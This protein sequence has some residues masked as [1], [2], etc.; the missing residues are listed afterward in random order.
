MQETKLGVLA[1]GKGTGLQAILDHIRLGVLVNVRT[2]C[3]VSNNNDAEVMRR[4]S[5]ANIATIFVEG[6]AGKKFASTDEKERRRREFDNIASKTFS[7]HGVDLIVC[8]GFN[9]VLSEVLVG[10]YPNKIMNI[11]PAYD[12]ARFGGIGMVGLKVHQAV[13]KAG[14]KVSGCTV[15]FIDSTVDRGPIILR[16]SVPVFEGDTPERLADRVSVI[17]HR[18]Y[19]KA[20]QLHVDRRIIVKN[21]NVVL[22]LSGDW[23]RIWGERQEE[24]IV[25]QKEVWK[26]TGKNIDEMFRAS[27]V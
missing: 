21:R 24:Y 14:E 16:A 1:S 12:I 25:Y 10:R 26:D 20:I 18:T 5:S 27:R 8:A 7:D 17:E 13:I 23:E 4:A 11:H 3:V 9:Q 19:P 22:D 2:V 15:H 6:I